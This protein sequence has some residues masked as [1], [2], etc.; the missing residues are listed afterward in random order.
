MVN[1]HDIVTLIY[2]V[3]GF[4]IGWLWGRHRSTS[5]SFVASVIVAIAGF[6]T[7]KALE[8]LQLLLDSYID[9]FAQSYKFLGGS[10]GIVSD[11]LWFGILVAIPVFAIAVFRKADCRAAAEFEPPPRPDRYR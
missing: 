10:A 8:W 2:G 3:I 1:L 7:G 11:V 5:A 4:I 6:A 9:K